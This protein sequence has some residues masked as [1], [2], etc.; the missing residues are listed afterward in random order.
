MVYLVINN[1]LT[2]STKVEL[3]Q[4]AERYTLSADT[5]RS[6]VM[7]LNRRPLVLSDSGE[8]PDLSPETAE[9]GSVTLE[10]GT[11]TFFVI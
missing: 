2:E 3:P 6:T 7:R 10:P 9:A 1:S 4:K 8:L 11:C 5:M